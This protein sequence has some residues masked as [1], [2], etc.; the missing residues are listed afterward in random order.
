MSFA[1]PTNHLCFVTEPSKRVRGSYSGWN[2]CAEYPALEPGRDANRRLCQG[3]LC[4]LSGAVGDVLWTAQVLFHI[5]SKREYDLVNA[6]STV[7][8][9]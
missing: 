6:A 3:S 2:V 8:L 5:Y 9:I 7:N 1:R 4:T